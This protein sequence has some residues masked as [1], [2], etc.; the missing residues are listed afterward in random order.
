MKNYFLHSLLFLILALG[1]NQSVFAHVSYFDISNVG[2]AGWDDAFTDYGFKQ[3]TTPQLATTDD[4]NWY[5]FHLSQATN[6]TLTLASDTTTSAQAGLAA[7]AFSLYSG[8]FVNDSFDTNPII[9]I[10]A[11]GRGL[12]NTAASFTLTTDTSTIATDGLP[13]D[14]VRTVNYLTSATDGG[15][16]V[17]D[18]VNYHLAAGDYTIIAGGNNVLNS[19]NEAA[20]AIYGATISLTSVPVPG[21]LWLM[22]SALA[23]LRLV[24]RRQKRDITAV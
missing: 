4:V 11:G 22:G 15:T 14:N 18:L 20:G 6:I 17:A 8:L 19:T 7:P 2:A 3:G 1:A 10:P 24:S 12:V 16:G 21:A 23:S 13:A 9:P 5:N